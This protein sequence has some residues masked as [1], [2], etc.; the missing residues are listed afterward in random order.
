MA[1]EIYDQALAYLDGQLL[2]EVTNIDTT[3][4]GEDKI[5]KTIAKGYAGVTPVPRMRMTK[6]DSMIL[7]SGME[8]AVER[9]VLENRK[10]ELGIQ[11]AGSGVSIKSL[12]FLKNVNIVVGVDESSKL[13]FEHSGEASAFSS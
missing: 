13:S 11:F 3:I 10:V 12:G 5:V 2:G 1:V 9:A 8:Y 7:S 4:D 6:I